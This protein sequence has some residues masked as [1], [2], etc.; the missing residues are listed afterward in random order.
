MSPKEEEKD[1]SLNP[2]LDLRR[3]SRLG[4]Q[5]KERVSL[6]GVA[7]HYTLPTPHQIYD[8]GLKR[9]I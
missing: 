7:V 1:M 4:S 8:R 5:K 9:T 6:T 2:L 3:S